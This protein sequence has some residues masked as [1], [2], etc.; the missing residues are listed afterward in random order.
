MTLIPALYIFHIII[1]HYSI[2][3]LSRNTHAFRASTQ[4]CFP[5]NHTTAQLPQGFRSPPNS[6]PR[7]RETP[8]TTSL[9]CTIQLLVLTVTQLGRVSP[10]GWEGANTPSRTRPETPASPTPGSTKPAGQTHFSS[11]YP[12][13]I[14]R[15]SSCDL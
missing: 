6:P 2:Y 14:T 3:S 15:T 5:C 9:P 13:P 11:N 10:Y 7:L 1:L 8:Y 12:P 4:P